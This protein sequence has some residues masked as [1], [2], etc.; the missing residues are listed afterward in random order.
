MRA[1]VSGVLV[2][3]AAALVWLLWPM[4]T[5]PLPGEGSAAARPAEPPPSGLAAA[6]PTRAEPPPAASD[7]T[8]ERSVVPFDDPVAPLGEGRGRV[9]GRVVWAD[10]GRPVADTGVHLHRNPSFA[11]HALTALRATTDPDGAF[12]FDDVRAGHY[13]VS[14]VVGGSAMLI[15]QPGAAAEV[16]LR[17]QR[18]L[19][20]H[21]VVHDER[22]RPVGGASIWVS[23]PHVYT[24]GAIATYTDGEGCFTL[25]SVHEPRWIGARARGYR[26]SAVSFVDGRP[27]EQARLELLLVRNDA[28]VRGFVHRPD[29]QPAAGAVVLASP[30]GEPQ[31]QRGLDGSQQRAHAPIA[32][33]TDA[34]GAFAMEGLPPGELVVLA[35]EEGF[36][37]AE[38]RVRVAEGDGRPAQGVLLY[39]SRVTSIDFAFARTDARGEYAV[40]GVSPGEVPVTL[41]RSGQ[42]LLETTLT[43]SPGE[44]RDFSPVLEGDGPIRGVVVDARRQPLAGYTVAVFRDERSLG[45][46]DTDEQGRFSLTVKDRDPVTVRVGATVASMRNSRFTVLVVDDVVAPADLVLEVPDDKLPSVS[47][48]GRVVRADG[49]PAA[50]T[51]V[52]FGG[53]DGLGWGEV[54]TAG[55][56]TFAAGGLL[57]GVYWLSVHDPDHPV[58]LLGQRQFAPH[59]DV[60]LGEIRLEQGGRIVVVPRFAAGTSATDLRIE[61]TDDRHRSLGSMRAAGSVLRSPAVPAGTVGLTVAGTGVACARH[62]VAVQAG[63]ETIVDLVVE[64]GIH[65]VVRAIV[66]PG[67]GTPKLLNGSVIGDARLLGGFA[68]QR[69]RD[70]TWRADVWLGP[71]DCDV[72]VGSNHHPRLAGRATIAGTLPAGAVVDVRLHPQ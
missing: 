4:D 27:G 54:R 56:G 14:T 45:H 41:W 55:D 39:F 58:A 1:L 47:I 12:A 23:A 5:D 60:D 13:A 22:G 32:T 21:G 28:R 17:V 44:A 8:P 3:L 72:W 24:H 6:A 37:K 62:E 70:G 64:P 34:S 69:Q 29:G 67:A 11:R 9:V 38:A 33:T 26:A 36:G 35:H 51:G 25:P 48:R 20:V 68:L 59:A 19:T 50:G 46:T 16:T 63:R 61:I 49:L 7:G 40:D 42:R 57:P 31:W 43:L 10:D 15:V 71:Q 52:E 30:P 53:M 65:R 2:L 18:G 66:P